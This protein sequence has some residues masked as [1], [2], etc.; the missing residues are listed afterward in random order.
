MKFFDLFFA[1][2]IFFILIFLSACSNQE[3]SLITQNETSSS[4]PI[5]GSTYHSPLS[6]NPPTLDPIYVQDVYGVTVVHQLF[7][8]LVRF[9]QHLSIAPAIAKSWLIKDNG[10]LYQFI[11]RKK[12]LFHNNDPVTSSDI[13]F[14]IKRILRADPPPVVLPHL[15]KIYGAEEYRNRTTNSVEGL[16]IENK[17][18]FK[19]RLKEPHFPFLT[20]LGMYQAAIVPEKEVLRL[21]KAF[22]KKPIGAGPFKLLSWEEKKSIHLQ[23]FDKYYA[24]PAFLEGIKYR[25]YERGKDIIELTDFKNGNLEEMAVYK[26]IKEKLSNV[27][28]LQWFH[29]PSLILF[30]YGINVNHPNL[31]NPDLRKALSLVIDRQTFINEVYDGQFEVAK[32]ILPPGIPGYSPLNKFNDNNIELARRY[33]ARFMSSTSKIIPELEI[34]SVYKTPR[35]EQEMEMMTKLW[36]TL[37]LKIKVKYITDWKKFEAYLKSDMVQIYRGIWS[38]DMPDPDSFMY[39]LFASESSVNY[40]KFQNENVDHMLSKARSTI[41]PLERANL[42]QKIEA[43]ILE[44]TPIIPLFYMSEDRVY[45]PYVKSIEMSAQGAHYM[46]LN[47]IWLD[48]PRTKN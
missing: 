43:S 33:I 21:G 15:L 48:K 31:T 28:N 29:R 39:S 44:Q 9:D 17:T 45:Q 14:S 27:K 2:F 37:G 42:Y 22:G 41:E 34:V 3:E 4:K 12:A 13:I 32:T 40:M 8:G 19:I 1:F 5:I 7:D 25:I 35:V 47:K 6:K 18:T 46:K 11:L 23:R 24:G 26:N 36:T 38:A 30:F 10:K 20:A 16:E